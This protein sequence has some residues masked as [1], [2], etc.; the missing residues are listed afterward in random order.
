MLLDGSIPTSSIH[1]KHLHSL[2]DIVSGNHV[3]LEPGDLFFPR[4][5][6]VP[7]AGPDL[8]PPH[9]DFA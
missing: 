5:L 7:P 2:K 6:T 9:S 8:G 1:L 3:A 4:Y